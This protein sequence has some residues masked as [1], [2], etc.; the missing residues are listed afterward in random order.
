MAEI[1]CKVQLSK[2]E[3]NKILHKIT[4]TMLQELHNEL[5]V[6]ITRI[7]SQLDENGNIEDVLLVYEDRRQ[8][9]ETR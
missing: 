5:G 4:T 1:E 3:I 6:V 8:E 7:Q 2:E 9:N